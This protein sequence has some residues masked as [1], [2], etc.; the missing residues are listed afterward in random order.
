MAAFGLE[1]ERLLT[2]FSY[3]SRLPVPDRVQQSHHELNRAARYFPLVGIAV[4]SMAAGSLVV[5]GWIWPL[6]VAVVLSMLSGIVL[7]G[8]MHEDGLADTT[9]G[10]GGGS[11]RE[12]VLAI[13]QDPRSGS[14]GVVALVLALLG[15]FSM[16][17]DLSRIDVGLAAWTLIVSHGVSR[18]SALVVMARL[19]YARANAPGRAGAIVRD[20]GSA[21]W[22]IGVFIGLVPL[23]IAVGLGLIDVSSALH[24]LLAVAL[25]SSLSSSYYRHRIGGYTGDCLGATQQI[26]E[27]AFYLAILGL[28]S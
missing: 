3:F 22:M 25:V 21:E 8:A 28:S 12:R 18:A 19:P 10:F 24:G 13:M 20:I 23:S 27:L 9:D 14:F 11:D 17:A 7:T 4:G 2:A 5:G 26:S 15:K 16:L 6:P 1:L